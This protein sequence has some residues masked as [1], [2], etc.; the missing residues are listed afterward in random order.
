MP[1]LGATRTK[2]AQLKCSNLLDFRGFCRDLLYRV[3]AGIALTTR[4]SSARLALCRNLADQFKAIGEDQRVGGFGALRT[5]AT[6]SPLPVS[7]WS[8]VSPLLTR[9]LFRVPAKLQLR[10]MTARRRRV[11][12]VHSVPM[13]TTIV[14]KGWEGP[15]GQNELYGLFSNGET[16]SDAE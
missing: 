6:T 12:S 2:T 8:P 9:G 11:L 10:A 4:R 13:A 3:S 7:I 15:A 16:L 5:P 14:A 1:K